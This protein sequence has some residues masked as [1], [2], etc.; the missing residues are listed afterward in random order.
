M[1]LFLRVFTDRHYKTGNVTCSQLLA[2]L[3]LTRKGVKIPPFLEN[4][5]FISSQMLT[6]VKV[7]EGIR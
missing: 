6:N 3:L 4:V 2:G 7:R 5:A 1:I